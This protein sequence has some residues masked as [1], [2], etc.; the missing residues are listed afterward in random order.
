MKY[1]EKVYRNL[2]L[3]VN[4]CVSEKMR[5]A[6]LISIENLL[7]AVLVF[8]FHFRFLLF[9]FKNRFVFHLKL[10]TFQLLSTSDPRYRAWAGVTIINCMY[11]R[12]MPK[13]KKVVIYGHLREEGSDCKECHRT[14]HHIITM[15]GT[16]GMASTYVD[17]PYTSF[18]SLLIQNFNSM[19]VEASW[20]TKKRW[21]LSITSSQPM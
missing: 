21:V 17:I 11:L 16:V 12:K 10:S 18:H 14:T 6:A 8:F 3:L 1:D 4:I 5:T 15:T 9:I 13:K 2:E 19:R 7:F 20:F